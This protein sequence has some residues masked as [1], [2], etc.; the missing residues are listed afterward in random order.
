[1]LRKGSKKDICPVCGEKRFVPYVLASDGVTPAGCNDQGQAYGRCDREQECGYFCYP[2]GETRVNAEPLRKVEVHPI[3]IS[4]NIFIQLKTTNS[5]LF[6]YFLGAIAPHTHNGVSEVLRVW[7]DYHVKCLDGQP[8]FFQM[9]TENEIHAAKLIPYK[10]DG[11]RDH[12]AKFPAYF[13]HKD[14]RFAHYITGSDL[15]QVFFGCHLLPLYPDKPVCVVESEKTALAMSVFDHGTHLWLATGGSQM[16][17]DRD[18]C[19]MLAGRDVTLYP[20]QGQYDQWSAVA[21][22]YGWKVDT[23]MEEHGGKGEDILDYVLKNIEGNEEDNR[24]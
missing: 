14:K 11:H 12:S 8:V 13:L 23:T 3:R 15:Q 5:S 1:M 19:E 18:R 6:V 16:I 4:L 22:R 7:I 24:L 21:N 17:K 2:K 20:D 9:D 10:A